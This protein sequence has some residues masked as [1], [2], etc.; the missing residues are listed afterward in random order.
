MHLLAYALAAVSLIAAIILASYAQETEAAARMRT[1][2]C[3]ALERA[4]GGFATNC[5]FEQR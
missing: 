5:T 2:A 3:I 4:R 1:S